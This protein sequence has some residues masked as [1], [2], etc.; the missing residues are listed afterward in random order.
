MVGGCRKLAFSP[1][2]SSSPGMYIYCLLL[3]QVGW[4]QLNLWVVIKLGSAGLNTGLPKVNFKPFSQMWSR[5]MRPLYLSVCVKIVVDWEKKYVDDF[6]LFAFCA[7]S[8]K[9]NWNPKVEK[10]TFDIPALFFAIHLGQVLQNLATFLF[11]CTT[12]SRLTDFS[13][14]V[15]E[16]RRQQYFSCIVHVLYFLRKKTF[17][18]VYLCCYS[19]KRFIIWKEN[20]IILSGAA[21]VPHYEEAYRAKAQPTK[22]AWRKRMP[23]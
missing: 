21:A 20:Q 17:V 7:F 10:K 22:E 18:Y 1:P 16:A 2:F 13:E 11:F 5:Q 9:Q 14:T 4:M 12:L 3:S 8:P 23:L 15:S 19:P 6:H